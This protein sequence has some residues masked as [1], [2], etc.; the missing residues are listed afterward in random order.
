MGL[1]RHTEAIQIGEH[2]DSYRGGWFGKKIRP[3]KLR[4][5]KGWGRK[6]VGRAVFASSLLFV[7]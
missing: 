1:V 3:E 7:S 4:K 5:G 6:V 2:A